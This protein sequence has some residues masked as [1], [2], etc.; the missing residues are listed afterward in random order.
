M[1]LAKVM[2]LADIVLILPRGSYHLFLLGE[3]SD[4]L[5]GGSGRAGHQA[6]TT[7][8]HPTHGGSN[9][10]HV[11]DSHGFILNDVA[12]AYCSHC[13]FHHYPQLHGFH[14]CFNS[15]HGQGIP[16]QAGYHPSEAR[17][18]CNLLYQF[19]RLGW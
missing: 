13:R 11:G 10:I 7:E 17:G 3:V 8:G 12:S 5:Y 14:G 16:P 1:A 2:P 6:G 19:G 18:W 9:H 15:G 4:I